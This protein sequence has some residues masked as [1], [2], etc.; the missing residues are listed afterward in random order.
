MWKGMFTYRINKG[1][2]YNMKNYYELIG[3]DPFKYLPLTFHIQNNLEDPEFKK[4]EEFFEKYQ[5]SDIEKAE[6]LWQEKK[7]KA[8]PTNIWIIKPG[9]NTNRGSGIKV[10]LYL[11]IK[12]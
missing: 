11:N 12:I 8:K 5:A 9:E 4:F 1:L 2:F 6:S 7:K 10:I 3:E